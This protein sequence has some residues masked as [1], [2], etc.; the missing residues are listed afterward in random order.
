MRIISFAGIQIR[1]V[2]HKYNINIPPRSVIQEK[3]EAGVW[4]GRP[5]PDP[6][7]TWTLTLNPTPT[8]ALTLALHP[9]VI[10]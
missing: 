2:K 1:K 9:S 5:N 10:V 4:S 7:L 6:N 3:Q 8:L